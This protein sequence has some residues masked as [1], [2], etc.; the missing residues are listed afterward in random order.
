MT[1]AWL[2]LALA[3]AAGC[4]SYSTAPKAKAACRILVRVDTITVAGRLD[5]IGRWYSSNGFPCG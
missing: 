3:F 4:N 1:R 2:T 5:T